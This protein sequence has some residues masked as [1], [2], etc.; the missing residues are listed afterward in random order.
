M[1]Q[2]IHNLDVINWLMQSYP[3]EANGMGGREVRIGQDNGQIYD[4]HFIEFTYGNGSKMY[5]QCR[6]IPNCWNNVSEHAH[7]T[8]GSV[9]ISGAKIYDPK[10]NLVW[11][12]DGSRG[13]HQQEHHDLFAALRRGERPNEGDYGAL[14]TMTAVFG[15]M[16]TYSGQEIRWDEALNSDISLGDVDNYHSFDDVAPVQPDAEG[17]YPVAVPGD[18]KTKII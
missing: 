12:S 4:H 17:R 10:G 2:H 15:R 1:E 6:H 8:Q 5:S 13:G 9:D 14:S 7:G 18:S 3:V 11:K 16:A